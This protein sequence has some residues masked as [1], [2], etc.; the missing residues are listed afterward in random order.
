MHIVFFISDNPLAPTTISA[1]LLIN[2]L[3]ERGF[4][5]TALSN[6]QEKMNFL[7]NPTCDMIFFQKK[8]GLGHGYNDVKHLKGRIPLVYIDDDFAGMT[9][10]HHLATLRN[11]D[12]I[13]VGNKQHAS[14]MPRYTQTPVETFVSIHDFANYPYKSP[15]SKHNNPLIISWQQSLAD[16]YINDLLSI[17]HVL[18][19]LNRKYN[20]RLQLYG[21]HKG[22]HYNVPDRRKDILD[23]FPF[24]ECI[25][26][27]PYHD[28]IQHIVPQICNSDINIAVYSDDPTR[29]GKS[30]FGLK[31]TMAMGVPIVASNVGVHQELFTNGFNGF[32]ATT[33]EQWYS[34]LAKLITKP[35]LRTRI[36]KNAYSYITTSYSRD[37]CIDI[38]IH[39]VQKHF[40][41]FK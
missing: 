2:A 22:E 24:A 41:E 20:I 33:P 8:I 1:N 16:V 10:E 21:W 36:S 31:R 29:I 39:A 40:P 7:A 9:Y 18:I 6:P 32:L 15:K 27:A 13:L 25:D 19:E 35:R 37:K 26:F 14:H 5:I 4:N 23:I 17:D 30:G 11:A 12:L 28:Y 34:Y 38:F 3:R